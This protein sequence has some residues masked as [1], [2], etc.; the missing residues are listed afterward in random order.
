MCVHTDLQ[1][2]L[3][4]AGYEK[5]MLRLLV[6]YLRMCS[7]L[8]ICRCLLL[9]VL[10]HH[11]YNVNVHLYLCQ[12]LKYYRYLNNLLKSSQLVCQLTLKP[13]D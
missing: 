9:W 12:Y 8:C 10:I 3:C 13:Y 1:F 5:K 4:L 7:S 11:K 6:L 2:F